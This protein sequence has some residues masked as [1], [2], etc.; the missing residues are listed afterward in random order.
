MDDLSGGLAR[1]PTKGASATNVRWEQLAPAAFRAR[2]GMTAPGADGIRQ[3][4]HPAPAQTANNA[5]LGA[6]HKGITAHAYARQ[7]EVEN[8][9]PYC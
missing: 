6:S 2:K 7:S 5:G 3:K 1:N 8:G 4:M 9:F